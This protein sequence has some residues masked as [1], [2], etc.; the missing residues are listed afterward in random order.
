MSKAY[1][2]SYLPALFPLDLAKCM[3]EGIQL[4]VKGYLH[5]SS[6]CIKS[7][8]SGGIYTIFFGLGYVR[9]VGDVTCALYINISAISVQRIYTASGLVSQFVFS[10]KLQSL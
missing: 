10:I 9:T 2:I 7:L 4:N 8:I 5:N 1:S 6:V 3:L